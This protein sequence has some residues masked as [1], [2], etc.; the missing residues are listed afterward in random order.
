MY[1][2]YYIQELIHLRFVVPN[3]LCSLRQITSV[4]VLLLFLFQ[5]HKCSEMN[6]VYCYG[7]KMYWQN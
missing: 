1:H 2:S 5:F 6:A 7:F 3:H 4:L